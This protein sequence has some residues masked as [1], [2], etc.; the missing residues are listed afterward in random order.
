M[1]ILIVDDSSTTRKV[2]RRSLLH[3]GLADEQMVEA[4][5]GAAALD[6]LSKQ[7]AP[8]LVLCDVNMPTMTGQELLERA[9]GLRPKHTFVMITSLCTT[10]KKLE[11]LG[12]GARKIIAKPF[13]PNQLGQMLAP[14]LPRDGSAEPAPATDE[15]AAQ[16]LPDG[17]ALMTLGVAVLQSIMQHMAFSEV[18]PVN[19]DPPQVPLFAASVRLDSGDKRWIVRLASDA[20]SAGELSNRLTGQDAGD[21]QGARL[22]AMR[23]LAN[24]MGG[25]LVRRAAGRFGDAVPGLPTSGLLAPGAATNVTMRGLRLVPGGHYV[26][27]DVEELA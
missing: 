20:P 4:G 23:E 13:D 24:I 14:Y 18:M 27:I 5:D 3:A 19:G 6:I 11:L 1:K 10:R 26:W 15:E 8:A 22:D 21:D 12:L 17:A 7:D 9:A 25:D 16:P 2:V